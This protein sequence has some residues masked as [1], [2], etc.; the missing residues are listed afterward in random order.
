MVLSLEAEE[1]YWRTCCCS[2]ATQS[3]GE[4]MPG[5]SLACSPSHN[6]TSYD[7]S[8]LLQAAQQATRN[9]RR[10]LTRRARK[11][12]RMRAPRQS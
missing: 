11:P 10:Q 1:M 3:R 8:F 12:R 4:G 5:G 6:K 2:S 7:A 9:P